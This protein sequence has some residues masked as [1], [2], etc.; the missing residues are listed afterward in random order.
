M[1]DN[2]ANNDEPDVAEQ[3]HAI[4]E[5]MLKPFDVKLQQR[6]S[7]L[8]GQSAP[9]DFS[10]P[11]EHDSKAEFQREMAVVEQ[12]LEHLSELI[13]HLSSSDDTGEHAET[14]R[15][16]RPIVDYKL[17]RRSPRSF[18]RDPIK[19][20]RKNVADVGGYTASLFVLMDLWSVMEDRYQELQSQKKEFWNLPHRAPDHYARAIALRLARLFAKETRQRPTVG[21][22]GE[23]GD[24]ST[25]FTRALKEVFDLLEIQTVVRSPAEWAIEQLTEDDLKPNVNHLVNFGIMLGKGP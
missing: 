13:E 2:I 19:L 7:T 6:A 22:S 16:V 9:F 18:V 1:Q 14:L 23:T 4:V 15:R 20:V 21:T 5:R 12:S 17:F 24:P 10:R 3:L 8:L 25:S 11:N